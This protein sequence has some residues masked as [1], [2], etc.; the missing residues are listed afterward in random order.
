MGR[1]SEWGLAVKQMLSDGEWHER[2]SLYRVAMKT[3]PPGRAFRA[4]EKARSRYPGGL[5]PR[6]RGNDETAIATGQ[7][8]LVTAV[9]VAQVRIGN[10]EKREDPNGKTYIRDKKLH[11][12]I[13]EEH[14][15]VEHELLD[16]LERQLGYWH[17]AFKLI[18][19]DQAVRNALL[20]GDPVGELEQIL[21]KHNRNVGEQ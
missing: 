9:L 14:T 2:E 5:K 17:N 4:A 7:R 10:Y 1:Q 15:A 13:V 12:K 20:G 3:V 16:V 6:K 21:S 8:M 11:D 19:G 18:G